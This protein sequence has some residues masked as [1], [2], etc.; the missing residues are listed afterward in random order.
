MAK[1]SQAQSEIRGAS[2][3]VR[4]IAHGLDLALFLIVAGAVMIPFVLRAVQQGGAMDVRLPLWVE[5]P[6]DLALAVGIICL[7]KWTG[8]TPGKR[9]FSLEIVDA[10]S[11]GAPTWG[12]LIRRYVGYLFAAFPIPFRM[13][14]LWNPELPQTPIVGV[15]FE[16]WYYMFLLGVGFFWILIDP[17]NR[18]WHDLMSGT[19][20]IVRTKKGETQ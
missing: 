9:L 18:G 15:L 4:G 20:T 2:F 16:K 1:D 11:G 17:K 3:F 13:A 14:T 10:R 7:W 6:I 19:V 12:Q 5:I 8:T